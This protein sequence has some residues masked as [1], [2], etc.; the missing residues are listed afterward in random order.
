M[1][2]RTQTHRQKHV[3]LTW[4][5]HGEGNSVYQSDRNHSLFILN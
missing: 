3:H 2:D 1:S 5:M 4:H